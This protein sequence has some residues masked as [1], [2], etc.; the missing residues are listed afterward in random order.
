MFRIVSGFFTRDGIVLGYFEGVFWGFFSV[1][2]GPFGMVVFCPVG[3]TLAGPVFLSLSTD[4]ARTCLRRTNVPAV[5]LDGSVSYGLV[6]NIRVL[7]E[8][9]RPIRVAR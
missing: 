3:G 4:A 7:V 8:A 2:F 6:R 9:L 5:R 1:G